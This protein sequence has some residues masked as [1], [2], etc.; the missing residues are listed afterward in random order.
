MPGTPA[1]PD[2]EA[3]GVWITPFLVNVS[4]FIGSGRVAVI[5]LVPGTYLIGSDPS[6]HLHIEAENVELMHA[7]LTFQGHRLS[8]E[9]LDSDGGVSIGGAR[10]GLPTPIQPG[11]EVHIGSAR[12][13]FEFD[14]E[15]RRRI[16]AELGDPVL[17][18]EAIRAGISKEPH[19]ITG[20]LGEGGM[21]VV[22]KA[23]DQRIHR[24][25]AMKVLRQGNEFSADKLLRFVA[26]AQLTGQLEHPNI[27]PVY[28]LGIGADGQVFYTMKHV[29]GQTLEEVLTR[30]R[31]GDEEIQ[32]QY[33]LASL[34][35]VF[36]KVADAIAFAHSHGVIHRDLK[37]ANI[38]IGS[39]GEVLVMDWGLAKRLAE[40]PQNMEGPH[41][42]TQH[43]Q[44]RPDGRQSTLQGIIAGTPP[45]LSPEQ[46]DS[47]ASLDQR[48]DIFVLGI[49][50][51]EILSLR[52]PLNPQGYENII[53][54]VREGRFI[55]LEERIKETGGGGSPSVKLIHCPGGRIPAG[56]MAVVQKAM[57]HSPI[58]RYQSV[59]ELQTDIVAY[60]NGFAPQAEEAS[61][62]RQLQLLLGRRR[63]EAV[64]VG[65]FFILSQLSLA[66]FLGRITADKK[67][68]MKSQ[69]ALAASNQRLEQIV[70]QLR[71]TASN[72]Y[73]DAITQLRFKKPNEALKQINL[74][75]VGV[76]DVPATQSR[77][78]VARGHANTQLG[79]YAEA[80]DDYRQASQLS[81]GSVPIPEIEADLNRAMEDGLRPHEGWSWEKIDMPAS[82][83]PRQQQK[84]LPQPPKP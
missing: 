80:L 15:V 22:L 57:Q 1:P 18:L 24:S 14:E 33:P 7:R 66:Y 82:N 76:A 43:S 58:Q 55:P 26:E 42:G 59:E 37:P 56:L 41:A 20:T 67:N 46:T 5:R 2:T 25:V 70:Y 19:Q 23:L 48:S 53:K 71:K 52:P 78:L 81:P 65:C 75:L 30:L 34:L 6:C 35:T 45:F 60:Q 47:R 49:I 39:F 13:L 62:F 64:M 83:K 28:Q 84:N 73:L 21:G 31:E 69:S 68:L 51:Y 79:F 12:L 77:Y 44:P 11:S 38:M 29:R 74:A 61:W 8:I 54:A 36:Q 3:P 40:P 4:V 27:I 9:D 17:G 50:L 72:N 32:N 63:R 16:E 10:L